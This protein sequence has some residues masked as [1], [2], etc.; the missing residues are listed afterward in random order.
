MASG[1]VKSRGRLRKLILT[2]Q[3]YLYFRSE[4]YPI[5]EYVIY[6]LDYLLRT[7]VHILIKNTFLKINKYW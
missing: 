1:S 5:L 6:S 4:I 2:R 3:S 7:Q